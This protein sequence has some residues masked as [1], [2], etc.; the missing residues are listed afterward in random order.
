MVQT[1]KTR[2]ENRKRRNKGII[3][4]KDDKRKQK[5]LEKEIRKR[6]NLCKNY[7][8]FVFIYKIF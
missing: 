3:L 5:K 4:K 1:N 6:N 8:I 7:K 2:K